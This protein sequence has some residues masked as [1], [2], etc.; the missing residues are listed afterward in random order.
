MTIT[1]QEAE[2]RYQD[3]TYG[4][5]LLNLLFAADALV[6]EAEI[7]AE[8]KQALS[9]FL[10]RSQVYSKKEAARAAYHDLEQFL[11]AVTPTEGDAREVTVQLSL[12]SR[13]AQELLTFLRVVGAQRQAIED[14][15]CCIFARPTVGDPES[16]TKVLVNEL[17]QK[18]SG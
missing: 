12:E 15:K 4:I 1:R 16:A 9:M 17:L 6:G 10:L 5:E 7:S 8:K 14:G 3:L 2:E 18:L 11:E 13:Q